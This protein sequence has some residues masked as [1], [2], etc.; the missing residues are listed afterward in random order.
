MTYTN[1]LMHLVLTNTPLSETDKLESTIRAKFDKDRMEK[2]GNIE[3]VKFCNELIN[4][5][6]LK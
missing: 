6:N 4:Q 3:G 1:S 5:L 2:Q